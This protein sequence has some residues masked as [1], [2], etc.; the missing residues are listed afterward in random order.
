MRFDIDILDGELSYRGTVPGQEPAE[1]ATKASPT[2]FEL[3]RLTPGAPALYYRLGRGRVEL[4]DDLHDLAP[5][6]PMPPPDP[7]VLLAMIHGL[8]DAP[9]ATPL[10]GVQELTLGSRLRVDRDGVRVLRRLP[11]LAPGTSNLPHALGQAIVPDA[12]ELAVAYSG[13]VA[14]SFVAVCASAA[15]R[16]PALFHADLDATWRH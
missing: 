11:Q 6:G 14:S 2:V 7:G 13:G 3:T 16:R 15:G 9:G 1:L 10:P 5:S 8:P 12:D 4:S